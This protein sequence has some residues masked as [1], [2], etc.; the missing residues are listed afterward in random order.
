MSIINDLAGGSDGGSARQKRR[1]KPAFAVC[2]V[3]AEQPIP[4]IGYRFF[5][6]SS[7]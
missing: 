1:A 2:S 6:T 4:V 7:Q 5:I 3:D